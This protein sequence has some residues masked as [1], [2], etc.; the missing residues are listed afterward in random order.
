MQ[1]PIKDSNRLGVEYNRVLHDA[2]KMYKAEKMKTQV[3]PRPNTST[4][5]AIPL[6]VP[7]NDASYSLATTMDVCPSD[8]TTIATADEMTSEKALSRRSRK[9]KKA[10]VKQKRSKICE[11]DEND[12]CLSLE[13]ER[14]RRAI[15]DLFNKLGLKEAN[16]PPQTERA[17]ELLKTL[18]EGNARLLKKA[19][20]GRGVD[21]RFAASYVEADDA[22]AIESTSASYLYLWIY[23]TNP[24]ACRDPK[25]LQVS[26]RAPAPLDEGVWQEAQLFE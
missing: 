10:P 11:R 22:Y 2:L 13:D 15:Y 9:E 16:E 21:R 20:S 23:R 1:P 12:V 17:R 3:Q 7:S 26:E 18:R 8:D 14:Y 24:R 4:A 19:A 25:R 5:D 6:A